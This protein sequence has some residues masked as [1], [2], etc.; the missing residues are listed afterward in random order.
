MKT[1][2]IKRGGAR[3]GVTIKASQIFTKALK[4]SE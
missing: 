1:A 2:D 4:K 3:P